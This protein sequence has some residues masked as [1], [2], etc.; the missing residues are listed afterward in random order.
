MY[1]FK[2]ITF[3]LTASGIYKYELNNLPFHLKKLIRIRGENPFSASHVIAGVSPG[4]GEHPGHQGPHEVVHAIA[5]RTRKG[6][7]EPLKCG[8]KI[9]SHTARLYSDVT[10]KICLQVIAHGD[11]SG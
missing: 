3:Y 4:K 5:D 2:A 10:C 1:L 9:S 6:R 7:T 11:S 8:L